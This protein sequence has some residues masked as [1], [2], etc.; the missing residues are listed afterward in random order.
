MGITGLGSSTILTTEEN[1]VL[2]IV[3]RVMGVKYDLLGRQIVT[4]KSEK[5]IS[6]KISDEQIYIA[7]NKRYHLAR[8]LSILPQ[9]LR[10]GT[11]VYV[12]I[13][14][15]NRL[16]MMVD[17]ARNAVPK[18]QTFKKLITHL[19]M[20]GYSGIQLYLEDLFCMEKYPYFGYFRGA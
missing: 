7:Y 5:E 17:C 1:T 14:Q 9:V 6:I 2:E 20:M 12:E 13:S 18:V 19:A 3:N 16:E 8:A 15:Y 4:A 11:D 10:A